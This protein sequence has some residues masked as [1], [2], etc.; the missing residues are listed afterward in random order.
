MLG[1][2]ELG[3]RY[4]HKLDETSSV[5]GGVGFGSASDLPFNNADVDTLSLNAF[6]NFSTSE[7]SAWV[8]SLF[9]SNNNPLDNK[10]PIPGFMY[11]YRSSD[12][13]GMFGLPFASIFWRFSDPWILSASIFGP[14]GVLEI[15]RGHVRDLQVFWAF[16]PRNNRTCGRT[17]PMQTTGFE[18]WKIVFLP[19]SVFMDWRT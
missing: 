2:I 8:L 6:Y 7:H 1:R 13:V 12:F 16:A 15:A 18:K 4:S 10:V 14:T 19:A 3:T 11:I 17:A 5:G 9:Y